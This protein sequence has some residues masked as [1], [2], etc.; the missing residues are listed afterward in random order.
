MRFARTVLAIV[1][2][3]STPLALLGAGIACESATCTMSC[4]ATHVFH[5][6]PGKGVICGRPSPAKSSQCGTTPGQHMP[7]F[8]AIAPIHL[9]TL[10]APVTLAAPAAAREPL[11]FFQQLPASRFLSAPFEPP[12]A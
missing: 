5:P 7:Q 1:T 8:G 12:R 11:V 3:L 9:S 4:C 6:Q 2:L 10:D